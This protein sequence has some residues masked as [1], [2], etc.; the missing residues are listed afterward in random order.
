MIKPWKRLWIGHINKKITLVYDTMM[1][2]YKCYINVM[3]II[4]NSYKIEGSEQKGKKHFII[5]I[6]FLLSH[7]EFY[8][9]FWL[10]YEIQIYLF[11]NCFRL[12]QNTNSWPEWSRR[13][14][15]W[16]NTKICWRVQTK[17]SSK[18]QW[19]SNLW[20]LWKPLSNIVPIL[21]ERIWLE[22]T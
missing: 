15:L 7:F 4:L 3:F 11:F 21:S 18:T 20:K 22:G 17:C 9:T 16:R 6:P 13:R 10:N 1:I 14:F 2:H 19:L 5:K 8:L 12:L